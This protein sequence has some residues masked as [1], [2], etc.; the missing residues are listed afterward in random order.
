VLWAQRSNSF[1]CA[2]PDYVN[3]AAIIVDITITLLT[4]L[5]ADSCWSRRHTGSK[6]GKE[7][8]LHV[9]LLGHH[10]VDQYFHAECAELAGCCAQE[11]NEAFGLDNALHGHHPHGAQHPHNSTTVA[12]AASSSSHGGSNVGQHQQPSLHKA[13]QVQEQEQ[14][15]P[16]LTHIDASGKASMV[17]VS[18]VWCTVPWS[19][20]VRNR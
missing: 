15:Q 2:S 7:Q 1:L 10:C 5:L 20:F 9:T 19:K 12:A 16:R 11:L 8:R 17:D 6:P 13:Q 14:E 18:Q 3:P 4:G